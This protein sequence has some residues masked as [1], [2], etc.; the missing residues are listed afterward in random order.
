M[1][2]EVAMGR[3]MKGREGLIVPRSAAGPTFRR[4]RPPVRPRPLPLLTAAPRN[5]LRA[6]LELVDSLGD[7]RF[8]GRDALPDRRRIPL[9]Q[10][11]FDVAH[12]DGRIGLERPDE[13]GLRAALQR[14]G[15]NNHRVSKGVDE[16][17]GV[18]ELIREER[19]VL[20]REQGLD[21]NGSGS[22]IDLVVDCQKRPRGELLLQVAIPRLD[23]ELASGLDLPLHGRELV[24]R[25]REHDRD[26]LELR[27]DDD[28]VG[29]VGMHDV[30]RVDEL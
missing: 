17:P 25:D 30:S 22:G 26:R 27:D 11:H 23:G 10:L 8:S 13:G 4:P 14:G 19:G 18:D 28:A 5:D 6:R 2:S 20:I 29:I 21:P 24:C 12:L 15:R 1:M 9:G 7:D 16:Q 3:R